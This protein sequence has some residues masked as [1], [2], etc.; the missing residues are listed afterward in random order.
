MIRS[1]EM[2]ARERLINALE[3]REVDRIPWSP[4]LAYVWEH[5]PKDIQD[6]GQCEFLKE[7]GADPLW[8]G[9]VCPVAQSTPG[10]EIRNIEVS[11]G[12]ITELVTPVG[13]IQL[14]YRL[15]SEGNTMFLVEHP[16]KSEEDFK[17]QLWIEEHTEIMMAD[18]G[19]VSDALSWDGLVIGMMTPRSKTAF[20]LLVEHLVGTE[21]L[22]YAL[23]DY[24]DT[25]ESLLQAMVENDLKAV[26][27]A[28][29][30]DLQYFLT[31]EDSSTQNYSPV[32]Y[33][34]YI[35]P[36][37]RSFCDILAPYGKSYIQHACGHVKDLLPIMKE[38]GVKAVE[39]LAS[40]PTGNVEMADARGSLGADVGIIGG[41][42]PTKFL[43]LSIRELEPYVEQVIADCSGGPFVLA[44]SDSCPPGVS[45]EKFKLV[46][47]I[48]RRMAG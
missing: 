19:P 6:R 27:L 40:P 8:R 26:R 14:R 9:A 39:S 5:F 22:A 4:F 46:G 29:E 11:D 42:E 21:E 35:A 38:S 37:I 17:V 10:M 18:Q 1:Q 24:P 32:M 34:K 44:N 47:Q 7:I 31:W 12:V 45:V 16:L 36:E 48:V 25:V 33:R 41:I 20:Q 23:Y 13:S 2:T 3:G 30:S 43:N 15:S 28:A